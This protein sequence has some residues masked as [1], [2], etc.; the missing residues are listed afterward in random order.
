IKRP[1][2]NTTYRGVAFLRCIYTF[3]CVRHPLS[4]SPTLVSRVPHRLT[5]SPPPVFVFLLRLRSPID[6]RESAAVD[7]ATL[8][9]S[10]TPVYAYLTPSPPPVFVFLLRLRSPV[11]IGNLLPSTSPLFRCNTYWG[12]M[13]LVLTGFS[14][15]IQVFLPGSSYLGLPPSLSL[16][17]S[18]VHAFADCAFDRQRIIR[19]C[20]A[21]TMVPLLLKAI[22]VVVFHSVVVFKGVAA[23]FNPLVLSLKERSLPFLNDIIQL[24]SE[25]EG[26]S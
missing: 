19:V 8:S 7:I 24:F 2:E 11:T 26:P 16:P 15:R 13:L 5:P 3:F 6:D 18:R 12:H 21:M 20:D 9:P 14:I 25:W 10:P 17:G 1:N 23:V 22:A 4:P